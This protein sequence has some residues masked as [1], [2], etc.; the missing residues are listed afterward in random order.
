M[1]FFQSY[2]AETAGAIGIV[3]IDHNDGTS[4]ETEGIFSM[5]TEYH[6]V[7]IPVLL[8]YNSEGTEL[9]G[10]FASNPDIFV[11]MGFSNVTEGTQ[12]N[13]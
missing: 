10:E 6:V 13:V 4:F 3:I 8:L 5:I 2:N 7:T 9:L 12:E 1:F 11:Y